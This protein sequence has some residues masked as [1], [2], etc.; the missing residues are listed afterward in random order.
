MPYAP[1]GSNR[2][3]KKKKKK[4]SCLLFADVHVAYKD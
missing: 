2:K 3:E 1:S 4:R